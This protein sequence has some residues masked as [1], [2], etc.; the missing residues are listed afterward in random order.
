[1]LWGKKGVP[2]ELM[3][4][5][6]KSVSLKVSLVSTAFVTY[7]IIVVLA[8]VLLIFFFGPRFGSSNPLVYITITASMG[9]ITV[10]ACKSLGVAFKE[11]FAGRNQ[12]L[13]PVT[14]AMFVVTVVFLLTQMNYLN[15]A[16]D[17]FSTSVVTPIL[18]VFYTTFVIIASA[19]LFKEW[20]K[21]TPADCLGNLT[22]FL[23]VVTGI[24]LLHA[25]KEVKV[26]LQTLGLAVFRREVIVAEEM[27]LSKPANGHC[28]V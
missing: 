2:Q 22:G 11:S 13:H 16:L 26:S 10:M 12:M 27:S 18:Y 6:K 4:H 20:H 9:S 3:F 14:I 8:N 5:F 17:I 7:T 15:R 25:C 19:I 23:T 24:F 1:M 21:L 28:G